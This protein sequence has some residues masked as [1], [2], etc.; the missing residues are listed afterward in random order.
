MALFLINSSPLF[1]NDALHERAS[2]TGINNTP[3]SDPTAGSLPPSEKCL[4]TVTDI[5]T[6]RQVSSS[7]NKAA[8]EKE[9]ISYATI[10]DT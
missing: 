7:L 10:D 9:T 2:K 4:L 8:R 5:S 3:I 6:R 1:I